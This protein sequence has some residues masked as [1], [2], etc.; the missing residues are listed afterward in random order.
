MFILT[1]LSNWGQI[2]AA[3]QSRSVSGYSRGLRL[4]TSTVSIPSPT[5]GPKMASAFAS[6]SP[7]LNAAWTTPGGTKTEFACAKDLLFP[8]EPLFDL[9]ADDEDDLFLIRMKVKALPLAW[10]NDPLKDRE[11]LRAS[12]FG[13]ADP[14]EPAPV[15]ALHRD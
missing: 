7:T 6:L 15:Q 9:A 2:M 13:A 8:V 5:H 14:A 1:R 10:E 4:N 3:S 12:L 11:A